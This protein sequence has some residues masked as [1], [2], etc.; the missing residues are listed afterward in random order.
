MHADP[1]VVLSII[2]IN[3]GSNSKSIIKDT[4]DPAYGLDFGKKTPLG[5]SWHRLSSRILCIPFL[6]AFWGIERFI[7]VSYCD[8]FEI[9]AVV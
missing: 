2:Y 1:W 3:K 7:R 4:H 9:W 6:R 8:H 5:V